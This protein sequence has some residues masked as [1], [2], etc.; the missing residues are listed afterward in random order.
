MTG[1]AY[2][3]ETNE[4]VVVLVGDFNPAIFQPRWLAAIGAFG[5]FES[6]ESEARLEEGLGV[7]HKEKSEFT[8]AKLQITVIRPRF[9]ITVSEEPFIRAKDFIEV[10]F[11]ELRHTPIRHIGINRVVHF[12]MR[13]LN[14]WHDLGDHLAPKEPWNFLFRENQGNVKQRTGGLESL[15]M[16]R[17]DRPDSR[18]GRITVRIGPVLGQ[19]RACMI[20]IND[21]ISTREPGSVQGADEILEIIND[22]WDESM[23]RADRY[24]EH[25]IGIAKEFD[26]KAK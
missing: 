19:E 9:L 8:T 10:V 11:S 13:S 15:A 22:V 25:L 17:V 5:S 2:D 3:L 21:H 1:F 26:L 12:S 7:V 20:D 6:E 24:I 23:E 18:K 16:R 14:A 4:A